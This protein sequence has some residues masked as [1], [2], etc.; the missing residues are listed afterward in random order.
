VAGAFFCVIAGVFEGGFEDVRFLYGVFVV[1]LWWIR[2][3]LWSVDDLFEI[4]LQLFRFGRFTALTHDVANCVA[5][6]ESGRAS[7]DAHIS[8]SRYGALGNRRSFDCASRDPRESS[9]T[10]FW[11]K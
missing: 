9:A 3:E 2:G 11:T 5:G 1:M 7:H 8:K 6:K 4:F 10:L